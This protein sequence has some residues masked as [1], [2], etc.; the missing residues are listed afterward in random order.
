MSTIVMIS[1]AIAIIF[2]RPP[3][4]LPRLSRKRITSIIMIIIVSSLVAVGTFKS[5][6][7]ER[8][9]NQSTKQ[10]ASTESSLKRSAF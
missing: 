2:W 1:L 4:Q 3:F 5:A 9:C 7:K 8:C 6:P 10:A